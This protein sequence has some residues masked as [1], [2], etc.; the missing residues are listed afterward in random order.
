MLPSASTAWSN[1]IWARSLK[2]TEPSSFFD[3]GV[4]GVHFQHRL[5][6]RCLAG[7]LEQSGQLQVSFRR[8]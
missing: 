3:Q 7:L 1:S 8:R 2:W 5:D 4:I 6:W